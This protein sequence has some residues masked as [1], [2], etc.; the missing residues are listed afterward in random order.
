MRV[1]IQR[2]SKASVCV[3]GG[4]S[5]PIGRGLVVLLG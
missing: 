5:R 4:S 2:V 3:N 1:L